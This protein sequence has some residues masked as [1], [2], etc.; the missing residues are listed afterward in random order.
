M[1]KNSVFRV[2]VNTKKWFRDTLIRCVRTFA[3]TAVSLLPTTYQAIG[4]VDWRFVFS[5]S[6]LSTIVIFFTCMAGIPEVES[7]V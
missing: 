6:C 3:A 5:A 2:S 4:S 7:E 1:F